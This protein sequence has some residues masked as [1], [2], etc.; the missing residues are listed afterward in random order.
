MGEGNFEAVRGIV[1]RQ[2]SV[3]SE[4]PARKAE[5]LYQAATRFPDVMG[6][7][8]EAGLRVDVRRELYDDHKWASR[9][10]TELHLAAAFDRT[11]EAAKLIEERG[12]VECRDKEGRTPLHLAASKGHLGAAKVLVS[13][14]AN[15]DARSKDGRTSL[16]RAAA[17]GD[18]RMVEML[19]GAEADPTIGDV[20][21]CRSAIDVARDKGHV[22]TSTSV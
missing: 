3:V 8:L 7:L 17:N 9:G 12:G 1:K 11:E 15:V 16:Y 13:A 20:D 22:S 2:Q 14:G 19:L 4:L 6:L 21:H 5:S 10:W 18:R